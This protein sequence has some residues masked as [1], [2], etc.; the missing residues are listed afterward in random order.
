MAMPAL[1]EH[2]DE[3]AA[4]GGERPV[5]ERL[6]ELHRLVRAR[7][8]FVARVAVALVDERSQ[9]LK[10]YVHSSGEDDPLSNYDAPLDEAPSLRRT[11]DLRRPRVVNDL[12]LFAAGEHDHTRRIW[13]HGYR[14]SYALPIFRQDCPVAIVFF[15]SLQPD[16][17][18]PEVLEDLDL[19]GHLVGQLVA[20]EQGRSRLL[21]AALRTALQMI[22]QRDAELGGHVERMA[23]YSRII[24]RHLRGLGLYELDDEVVE[25]IFQF[26]PLHDVGK[27]AIPDR[28]LRKTGELDEEES[29]VMRTHTSLGRQ[30]V[31]NIA[32]SLGLENLE[33]I[34]ILRWVTELHHEAMDGSGYPKCLS[35]EE[36]P[37]AARIV[38]VADVFDALTTTRSYK[39]AWSND[40]AFAYL[41]RQGDSTLDRHCIDAM[42]QNR[43]AVERVQALFRD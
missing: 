39:P 18:T 27:I 3:L 11:I 6:Q 19:Y 10:T 30:L 26:A 28:V 38:A 4:L 40:E 17:F 7:H 12:A 41:R 43:S 5:R 14:A 13:E 37:I 2:Q 23:H 20:E 15:N 8:P 22:H 16:C 32:R 31:D 33:Q 24:A 42:I 35:G 21:L 36:I 34:D 29:A 9:T 25:L 1:F